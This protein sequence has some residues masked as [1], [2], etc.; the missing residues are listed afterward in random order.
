[1]AGVRAGSS[2]SPDVWG[3][4]AM[5]ATAVRPDPH[6]G[7]A[8]TPRPSGPYRPLKRVADLIGSF[9]LLAIGSPVMLAVAIAIRVDS[10][11]PAL[12]R[13]RR[14]GRRSREFVI[15]KFRTM[16][17]GT[18]D[19]ASHLMQEQAVSRIT[20]IGGFLRRTSLDELPQLFNILKGDMSFVGPRPALHNQ[21]DLI[22]MRQ[23]VEVDALKPG[24]TGWA[25]ING[26]DDIPMDAKVALD[27]WYLDHCG[28]WVDV[29][30]L[31]RTPFA[32]LSGRGV[33]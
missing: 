27:R 16:R 12:F 2:W 18:P 1:V 33:N 24:V 14:I 9:V 28:L 17:E 8:V 20:R 4:L 29:G 11:G 19:L 26:R 32:L 6:V 31:V 10:P 23:E 22:A 21:Y 15:F 13:Q 3:E 7:R 5:T 30:I 25:Q